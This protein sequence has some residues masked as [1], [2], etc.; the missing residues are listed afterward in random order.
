MKRIFFF[1]AIIAF[2]FILCSCEREGVYAPEK[3]IASISINNEIGLI[4]KEEWIWEKDLL[5]GINIDGNDGSIRCHYNGKQLTS[6]EAHGQLFFFT[7]DKHGRKLLSMEGFRN[8]FDAQQGRSM[9]QMDFTYNEAGQISG[10]EGKEYWNIINDDAKA[11]INMQSTIRRLFPFLPDI[12][13]VS[14][15]KDSKRTYD[16][17]T[18]IFNYKDGNMTDGTYTHYGVDTCYFQYTYTDYPNPYFK[19]FARNTRFN[20]FLFNRHI[21]SINLPKECLVTHHTFFSDYPIYYEKVSYSY[22]LDKDGYPIVEKLNYKMYV[23]DVYES[24][25]IRID[26]I[27]Y[28]P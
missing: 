6:V 28:L 11:K 13:S 25:S 12:S 10:F 15:S 7:Y 16:R 4:E 18:A 22:E 9:V 19:C 3:R 21:L 23:D 14:N 1:T 8:V 17:I 20:P 26:Q 24:N 27:E 5:A 2:V